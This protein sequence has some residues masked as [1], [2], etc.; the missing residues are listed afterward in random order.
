MRRLILL[1]ITWVI[2]T[3]LMILVLRLTEFVEGSHNAVTFVI[4][5]IMSG[6][7][8]IIAGAFMDDK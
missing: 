5:G 7:I 6:V 2:T 3:L 4:I 8:V 1:P